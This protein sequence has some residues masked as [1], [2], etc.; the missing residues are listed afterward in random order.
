VLQLIA[1]VYTFV[2]VLRGR[3]NELIA[4]SSLVQGENSVAEIAL[5]TLTNR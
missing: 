3:I 5:E 1:V 4:E 2:P